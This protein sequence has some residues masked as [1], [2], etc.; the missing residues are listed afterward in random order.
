MTSSKKTRIPLILGTMTIANEGA[1]GSR[2]HDLS[3]AQKVIDVFRS[4]GHTELDTARLYGDGTTEEMLAKLDCSGLS[5]D[6]KCF[7]VKPGDH[8]PDRVKATL[9]KILDALKVPKLRVFYLHAPDRSVPF[10]ETLKACDALY[11]E[12]KFAELGLSNFAAWEVAIIWGICDKNNYVKPTIY[13]GMYNAITRSIETELFPCCRSLGI[14]LVLYNPLA[15]G[16]FAGKIT[17]PDDQIEQGGRFDP[18]H[19]QGVMYRER[20]FRNSYFKAL[21]ILKD[22]LKDHPD[23]SLVSVAARWLQHHSALKPQ[24][25]IIFGASSVDQI[26]MNCTESE[27]GPLPDNILAA[28]DLAWETVKAECPLYWR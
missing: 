2:I 9:D 5:I 7:P 14:R 15:G 16:F 28:V 17:K 11:H 20:Y 25:G 24:D 4:H 26:E 3:T 27:G 12:G 6:S 10:E 21:E 8:K 22:A 1:F 23:I 13:Q 19:R 18:S